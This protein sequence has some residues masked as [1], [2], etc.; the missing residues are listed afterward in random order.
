MVKTICDT[1]IFLPE[2]AVLY[3]YKEKEAVRLKIFCRPANKG[4][5]KRFIDNN[6]QRILNQKVSVIDGRNT[7]FQYEVI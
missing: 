5:L 6:L 1:A 2:P 7:Y 4:N 3:F